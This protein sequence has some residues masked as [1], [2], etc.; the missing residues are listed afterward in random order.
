M[1][2]SISGISLPNW[3]RA[4]RQL[5][6]HPGNSLTFIADQHCSTSSNISMVSTDTGI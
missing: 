1:A 2:I 5:S 6:S 4:S 3:C